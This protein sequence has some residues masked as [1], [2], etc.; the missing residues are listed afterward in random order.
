M[1]DIF[2]NDGFVMLIY[3][4]DD[5]QGHGYT[6]RCQH[7]GKERE[8]LATVVLRVIPPES[9]EV[10]DGGVDHQLDADQYHD[11]ITASH[12]GIHTNGKQARADN[13]EM[14]KRNHGL[15]SFRVRWAAPTNA[16][17]SNTEITSKGNRYRV[18]SWTPM[19][20][21]VLSDGVIVVPAVAASVIHAGWLVPSCT[22]AYTRMARKPPATNSDCHTGR[23]KKCAVPDCRWSSNVLLDSIKAK[24]DRKSTRLN[25]SHV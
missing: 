23:A 6:C 25:S 10:E 24:R 11:G 4:E 8:S 5:R 3:V 16:I 2:W 18:I 7:D 9:D 12:D 22:D 17:M 13:E 19:C 20:W 21:T 1:V 14:G 15:S